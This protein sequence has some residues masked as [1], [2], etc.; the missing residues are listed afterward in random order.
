MSCTWKNAKYGFLKL[1]Y[2][3]YY[4]RWYGVYNDDRAIY[5]N[6][7]RQIIDALESVVDDP[8]PLARVGLNNAIRNNT[9]AM[10]RIIANFEEEN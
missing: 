6:L 7:Y 9:D 3:R 4:L 10:D 1:N 8:A 2:M 5:C